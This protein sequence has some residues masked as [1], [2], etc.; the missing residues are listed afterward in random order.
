MWENSLKKW[1]KKWWKK[2]WK[3]ADKKADKKVYSYVLN[4]G[5]REGRY[6]SDNHYGAAK[7]I[8]WKICTVPGKNFEFEVVETSRGSTNKIKTYKGIKTK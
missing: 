1:W 7:K 6:K 3:K 5:E 4:N 2:T 8:A